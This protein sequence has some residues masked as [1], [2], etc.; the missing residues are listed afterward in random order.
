MTDDYSSDEEHSIEL[1]DKQFQHYLKAIKKAKT[2]EDVETALKKAK[3]DVDEEQ[4]D[5][6]DE[7][8]ELNVYVHMYRINSKVY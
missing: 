5:Q 1:E 6:D 2:K 8:D 7:N 3:E 4:E